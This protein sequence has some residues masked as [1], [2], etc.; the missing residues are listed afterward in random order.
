MKPWGRQQKNPGPQKLTQLSIVS[1]SLKMLSKHIKS[2]TQQKAISGKYTFLSRAFVHPTV[3]QQMI[4][5]TRSR[6]QT[7]MGP[8]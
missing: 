1:V 2:R 3:G 8:I 6:K 5:M 4:Q 7:K